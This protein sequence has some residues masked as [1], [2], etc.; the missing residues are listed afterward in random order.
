MQDF[1]I[2]LIIVSLLFVSCSPKINTVVK[3]SY[4]SNDTSLDIKILKLNE[5]VPKGSEILGTSSVI[6]NGLTVNC[7]YETI[8][9]LMKK[10]ARKLGGNAIKIIDE[11]PSNIMQSNCYKIKA[12][13]LKVNT[14]YI[15]PVQLLKDSCLKLS[16][17]AL[18]HIYRSNGEGNMVDY[19]LNIARKVIC[20]V[21]NKWKKNVIFLGDSAKHLLWA[22]KEVRVEQSIQILPGNEYYIRCGVSKGAFVGH[23]KIEIVDD[24][25][26]KM[27]FD[28]I[29]NKNL[30]LKDYLVLNNGKE[31]E[32]IVDKEEGDK[33]Y[34]EVLF[35]G[36][37]RNTVINRSEVKEIIIPK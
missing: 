36:R 16:N 28:L 35:K 19:D 2:F 9:E 27:Q 34:I 23:P 24:E 29:K 10:D 33:I 6:D 7:N 37:L 15:E 18:V 32:C 11:Q 4:S 25:I 5:L 14:F 20:N 17:Y 1:K 13:I 22:D 30:F 21:Q 31:L 3:K 8:I 12:L 26:G